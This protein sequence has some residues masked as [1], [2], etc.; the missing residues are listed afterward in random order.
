MRTRRAN[1]TVLVEEQSVPERRNKTVP[2]KSQP[3]VN[4]RYSLAHSATSLNSP[5]KTSQ[6]PHPNS[7][8]KLSKSLHLLLKD[9]LP[10]YTNI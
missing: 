10:S 2:P 4:L 8:R 6:L 9:P 5:N 3:K 1:R 7:H